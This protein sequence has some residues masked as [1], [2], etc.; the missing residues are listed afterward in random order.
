MKKV[1]SKGV[2][3]INIGKNKD[4]PEE[5]ALDDYLI[6]LNKAYGHCDYITVNI[7]SPNTPGLRNLQYGEALDNLLTGLK[8]EQKVL[9]D[10]HDIYV[11]IFVKIAPDLSDEEIESIAK[12]LIDAKM[13]GVIATNTTLSRDAVKGLSHG[14]EAGGL[15]GSVLTERSLRVTK[16]LAIKLDGALPIIG[17][18]G[19]DCPQAALNQLAAGASLVQVYSAFIY[20]GPELINQIV[21]ALW[22]KYSLLPAV[23]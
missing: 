13:D 11:P 10:K 15:S 6:C 14:D 12:S 1:K 4:T 22:H 5:K 21:E 7:S 2:V 8:N 17:V 19:I 3:G 23:V 18:G 9:A 16:K 20:Q